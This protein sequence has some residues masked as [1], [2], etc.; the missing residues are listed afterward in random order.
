[1][2]FDG[3][4]RVNRQK[5]ASDYY[6]TRTDI[7]QDSERRRRRRELEERQNKAARVIQRSFRGVLARRE[8]LRRA[9]RVLLKLTND[10]SSACHP[11]TTTTSKTTILLYA[12]QVQ[13]QLH[14][15]LR[16][17]SPSS[18]FP[19]EHLTATTPTGLG[20]RRRD[21]TTPLDP[22]L[23]LTDWTSA[24]LL[25]SMDHE[26][27][28]HGGGDGVVR[29]AAAA[30]HYEAIADRKAVL[31]IRQFLWCVAYVYG[32]TK[33]LSITW[34]SIEEV[35]AALSSYYTPHTSNSSSPSS[36]ATTTDAISKVAGWSYQTD[37]VYCAAVLHRSVPLLQK[38][39]FL[40]LQP[41]VLPEPAA[42]PAVP[43][44]TS[45]QGC[46]SHPQAGRDKTW[47][48][49]VEH[50]MGGHK[51][52]AGVV[53]AVL[54]SYEYE[55]RTML[56]KTLETPSPPT[57][58][59]TTTDALERAPSSSS[60][61][62]GSTVLFLRF[63]FVQ[64]S[65][66]GDSFQS[67]AMDQPILLQQCIARFLNPCTEEKEEE[68]E[69]ACKLGEIQSSGD[70]E[71]ATL[72]NALSSTLLYVDQCVVEVFCAALG[73]LTERPHQRHY[74]HR[75]PPRRPMHDTFEAS[76]PASL[77]SPSHGSGE[78]GYP[79]SV[80]GA[81]PPQPSAF[82]TNTTTSSGSDH[83]TA[84]ARN[85][86]RLH[87]RLQRK[88]EEDLRESLSPLLILLV[89]RFVLSC[90][91]L[92]QASTSSVLFTSSSTVTDQQ[93]RG[94]RLGGEEGGG[95]SAA[96]PS[97]SSRRRPRGTTVT[98]SLP[99]PIARAAQRHEDG[100]GTGPQVATPA[101]AVYSSYSVPTSFG[102]SPSPFL[103]TLSRWKGLCWDCLC[104]P[105]TTTTTTAAGPRH[106]TSL[107]SDGNDN[108][109]A[110]ASLLTRHPLAVLT[111]STRCHAASLG[112]VRGS[113]NEALHH[114]QN[115]NNNNNSTTTTPNNNNNEDGEMNTLE[116][117][118]VVC[119]LLGRGPQEAEVTLTEHLVEVAYDRIIVQDWVHGGSE[120]KRNCTANSTPHNNNNNTEKTTDTHVPLTQ[121]HW[122][123]MWCVL[124]NLTRLLPFFIDLADPRQSSA[125]VR[126]ET[127]KMN[128]EKI[129]GGENATAVTLAI[130]RRAKLFRQWA[131]C[132]AT[133]MM[134]LSQTK[135]FLRGLVSSLYHTNNNNHHDDHVSQTTTTTSSQRKPQHFPT[136]TQLCISSWFS[137]SGGLLLLDYVTSATFIDDPLLCTG[138]ANHT[139]GTATTG[140]DQD[141]INTSL[142][143][144]DADSTLRA[145]KSGSR[146]YLHRSGVSSTIP[147]TTPVDQG[148]RGGGDAT[149]GTT[150]ASVAE[151]WRNRTTLDS[152][153]SV[154]AW[155]LLHFRRAGDALQRETS[156]VFSRLVRTPHIIRR[157][158]CLYKERSAGLAAIYADAPTLHALA[159]PVEEEEEEE[160]E[161][162][163]GQGQSAT[164]TATGVHNEGSDHGGRGRVATIRHRPHSSSTTGT[165]RGLV[166][167]AG[168]GDLSREFGLMG[169]MRRMIRHRGDDTNAADPSHHHRDHNESGE[170]E[171]SSSSSEEDDDDEENVYGHLTA[172]LQPARTRSDDENE[173]AGGRITHSRSRQRRLLGFST[174]YI[175]M[176]RWSPPHPP[177][178]LTRRAPG[179]SGY[180]PVWEPY[181]ELAV[182]TFTLLLYYVEATNITDEVRDP[183][184]KQTFSVEDFD[185]LILYLREVVFRSH[186]HGVLPDSNTEAVARLGLELLVKLHTIDEA[187]AGTWVRNPA[188]WYVTDRNALKQFRLLPV[189][190]LEKL[191]M[192]EDR[193]V[194]DSEEEEEEG[195]GRECRWASRRIP[196]QTD[197]SEDHSDDD[198]DDDDDKTDHQEVP[199]TGS[200]VSG[201]PP[202]TSPGA[203]ASSTTHTHTTQ[204][205][206]KAML[207]GER[208]S[209]PTTT[210][211]T[212]TLRPGDDVWFHD[213]QSWGREERFIRLLKRAPFLIPFDARAGFFSH[214]IK[215]MEIQAMGHF[216]SDFSRQNLKVRRDHIFEDAFAQFRHRPNASEMRRVQ[217]IDPFGETEAGMGQGV[218]REFL[219]AVCKD[220]FAAEHGLFCQ[221]TTGFLYPN[222]LS[223]EIT[224]DAQ[225]LDKIRFLG[226]IV[227]RAMRD[228]IVQ[229]VPLAQHFVNGVLGRRNTFT[230]LKAFDAELHRHLL[231]LLQRSEEEM[232]AIGLTFTTMREV[233]GQMQEVDLI[234][235][236]SEIAVTRHNCAHY[237]A[238]VADF[239]LNREGLH[240]TKAFRT[241][242]QTIITPTILELFDCRETTKLLCGDSTGVIDVEDWKEHTTYYNTKDVEHPS[243]KL[244][245]RVVESLSTRQKSQ[246]LRFATSMSFPP[247]LGFQFLSPPFHI[248]LLGEDTVDR[249]PTATTCFS[250]LKLPPYTTFES[251]RTK[252]LAAVEGANSF[253]FS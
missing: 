251:A 229:E 29:T 245:W 146:N 200:T 58:E 208:V 183:A 56:E 199:G 32:Y 74:R 48:A 253:E 63:L 31:A 134:E 52:L 49:V 126:V 61:S 189:A 4:S 193:D 82:T 228:G 129:N 22:V 202:S 191:D 24:D 111:G 197:Y 218:Y 13:K 69:T 60:S 127:Q 194:E 224:G 96:L 244:F 238:L 45:D 18:P 201:A 203:L 136:P 131:C 30:H 77:A 36:T 162:R 181:P 93:Q 185:V 161:A 107:T 210:T 237:V 250:T 195:G 102:C 240:Q 67:A 3:R 249:L 40:L 252:I 92:E 184:G 20:L 59:A 241:G 17:G 35:E 171:S 143:G 79:Y 150:E 47:L 139:T 101:A 164:A 242:L 83:K 34:C 214:F 41:D 80:E 73:F 169:F 149:A 110:M 192:I 211:T 226:A 133:L 46:G 1:M 75:A 106:H 109:T 206:L 8:L 72:S 156:V 123:A 37:R 10:L 180:S 97:R 62:P 78:G 236:G 148:S 209:P 86:N 113:G 125:L 173:E 160:E 44:T 117:S 84:S 115:N 114:P 239:R 128:E 76:S 16:R 154:F 248:H 105:V 138:E 112:G 155:P 179:S 186:L 7:L 120:R 221:T 51:T 135:P 233:V 65:T 71:A 25:E 165:M 167:E 66:M 122:K 168:E 33:K 11:T 223:L 88:Q 12:V 26:E 153:C 166:G 172:P 43:T 118:A 50:L 2:F 219:V 158:W 39:L 235:G 175:P 81:R 98:H 119:L 144:L 159:H 100:S 116:D 205:G 243:V 232:E 140:S 152:L 68:E 207:G 188:I 121:Q 91:R 104:R 14:R 227:G 6:R 9:I 19:S 103:S 151:V 15:L 53:G 70:G 182:L 196:W 220:G 132:V 38:I 64:L 89:P 163:A 28:D 177:A 21:H 230:H 87:K 27:E 108:D 178:Q 246:L 137:T 222:P 57:S 54:L 247:L 176:P 174:A 147:G 234:P 190:F 90:R 130:R 215:S 42:V 141:R 124:T 157:L 198:D 212:T 142:N 5:L 216:P 23:L 85:T 55:M 99:P 204:T 187:E 217:F 95:G 94:L 213:S 231:E 170:V 145:G 225:H